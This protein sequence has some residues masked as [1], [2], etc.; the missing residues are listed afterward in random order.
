MKYD[1]KISFCYERADNFKEKQF[2]YLVSNLM[3]ATYHGKI[4]YKCPGHIEWDPEDKTHVHPH[5]E[6]MSEFKKK[7][8]NCIVFNLP[9]SYQNHNIY[10]KLFLYF[11]ENKKTLTYGYFLYNDETKLTT[12]SF[13]IQG[14]L[15]DLFIALNNSFEYMSKYKLYRYYEQKYNAIHNLNGLTAKDVPTEK[16]LQKI[17][18]EINAA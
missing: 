3:S 7:S 12:H 15:N 2:N 16:D 8:T 13:N 9:R 5:I 4:Q 14:D 11:Y 18:N 17:L 6:E 10:N 1:L